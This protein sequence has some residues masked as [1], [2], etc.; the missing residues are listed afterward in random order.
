MPRADHPAGRRPV[1]GDVTRLAWFLILLL[2]ACKPH[3]SMSPLSE[4]ERLAF[5]DITRFNSG[6][7]KDGWRLERRVIDNLD[8]TGLAVAKGSLV[9]V[10]FDETTLTNAQFTATRFERVRFIN[11]RFPGAVF[12]DCDFTGCH[13]A[14]GQA[15]GAIFRHCRFKGGGTTDAKWE[16][17]TLTDCQ[18]TDFEAKGLNLEDGAV[19]VRCRWENSRWYRCSLTGAKVTAWEFIGGSMEGDLTWVEGTKFHFEGVSMDQLRWGDSKLTDVEFVRCKIQKCSIGESQS[20]QVRFVDCPDITQLRFSRGKARQIGFQNCQNADQVAFHKI[21]MENLTVENGGKW[22]LFEITDSTVSGRSVLKKV[23]LEK[24][25]FEGT[26]S[27]DLQIDGCE[28]TGFLNLRNSK[29]TG[30][31][32]NSVAFD[33]GLDRMNAATATFE[34]G[35]RL[36]R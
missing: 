24:A 6:P 29:F 15:P 2:V 17:V 14:M 35:D 34:N 27:K 33:R 3:D 7:G 30:L 19:M 10:D 9:Q 21:E 11:A 25:D 5:T 4:R 20:S 31:K 26:Q 18:F 32:L 23:N 16:K 1:F 12:D 22:T 13:F 8:L 28:F 36:D